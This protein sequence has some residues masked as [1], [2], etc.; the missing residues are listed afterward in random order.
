VLKENRRH[1]CAVEGKACE[2]TTLRC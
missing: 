1:T 2:A